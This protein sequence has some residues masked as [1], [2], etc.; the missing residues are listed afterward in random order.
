MS[1]SVDFKKSMRDEPSFTALALP[2]GFWSRAV[3]A[4]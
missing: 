3:F 2:E 1:L 4:A